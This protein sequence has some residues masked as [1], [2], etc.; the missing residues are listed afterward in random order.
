MRLIK[1]AV[2][3]KKRHDIKMIN[4]GTCPPS[5]I[6]ETSPGAWNFTVT[7]RRLLKAAGVPPVM[8]SATMAS[9]D[10][11]AVIAQIAGRQV[12]GGVPA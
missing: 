11:S 5:A 6:F 12:A 1:E 9:P 4:Y 8:P 2:V 10:P 3:G 7:V